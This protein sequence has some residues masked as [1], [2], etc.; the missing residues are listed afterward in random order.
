MWSRESPRFRAHPMTLLQT[1]SSRHVTSRQDDVKSRQTVT[2]TCVRS[3]FRS[4]FGSVAGHRAR[5]V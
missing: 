1:S 3:R 2:S 4:T 5:R